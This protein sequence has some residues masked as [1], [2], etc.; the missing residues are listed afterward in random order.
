M[1]TLYTKNVKFE[2][3]LLTTNEEYR[4]AKSRNLTDVKGA[5]CGAVRLYFV[6]EEPVVY[7]AI[8]K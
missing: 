1:N 7:L 2:R 4:Y 3:D 5:C 8:K 6:R